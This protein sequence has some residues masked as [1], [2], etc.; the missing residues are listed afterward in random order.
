MN[1][2]ASPMNFRH[3]LTAVYT[4][5]MVFFLLNLVYGSRGIQSV[6]GLYLQEQKIRQNLSELKKTGK[7]LSGELEALKSS[8]ELIRL[9]AR[10]L[11]YFKNG[12]KVLFI[13]GMVSLENR[14]NPGNIVYRDPDGP[15]YAPL[16][17]ALAFIAGVFILFILTVGDRLKSGG[18]GIESEKPE[19]FP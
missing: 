11:G 8:S 2:G 16:F 15:R 14:R 18:Y 3:L 5:C 13:P 7:L 4:G 12:E 17:R 19:E 10:S 1:P 6:G 9:K